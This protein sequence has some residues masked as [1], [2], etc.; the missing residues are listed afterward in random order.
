MLIFLPI[1]AAGHHSV[2]GRYDR[3]RIVELRGSI[4]DVSWVN[5]HVQ[6]VVEASDGRLWQVEG[7]GRNDLKERGVSRD[8]FPVGGPV[9]L[10]G[11]AS[12]FDLPEMYMGNLL[13]SNGQEVLL[14]GGAEPRWNSVATDGTAVDGE[15]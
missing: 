1:I 9:T 10:A 7:I 14:A 15:D 3:D 4:V 6:I 13:L 5:P 8:M 12:R 2:A 11:L